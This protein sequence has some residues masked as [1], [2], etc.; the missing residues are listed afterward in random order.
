MV[1]KKCKEME[2]ALEQLKEQ[3]NTDNPLNKQRYYAFNDA[4]AIL[5]RTK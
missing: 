3:N 5:R 2:E 4:L 1:C